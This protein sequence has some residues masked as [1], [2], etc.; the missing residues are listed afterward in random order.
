[1]KFSNEDFRVGLKAIGGGS[2]SIGA[3]SGD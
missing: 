2:Q 3:G 1:M